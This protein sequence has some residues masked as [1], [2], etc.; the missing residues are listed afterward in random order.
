MTY[1]QNIEALLYILYFIDYSKNKTGK[2][3]LAMT[4]SRKLLIGMAIIFIIMINARMSACVIN[5]KITFFQPQTYT[6]II[7]I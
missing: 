7:I 3:K 1:T 6:N 5:L 4:S 2:T